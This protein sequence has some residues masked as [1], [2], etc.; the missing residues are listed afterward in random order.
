[1]QTVSILQELESN[2]I[3]NTDVTV[4]RMIHNAIEE[5]DFH[6][7]N[8]IANKREKDVKFEPL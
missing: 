4:K 2:G 3:E 8:K 7:L 6:C 1:M 5:Q